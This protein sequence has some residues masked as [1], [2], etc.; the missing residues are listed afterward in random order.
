[1][2]TVTLAEALGTEKLQQFLAIARRYCLFIEDQQPMPPVVFLPQVQQLLLDLYTAALSLDWINLQSKADYETKKIDLP[3]ILRVVAEKLDNS[4][5]YWS[6]FDPTSESD[7]EAGCGDLLD[8]LGDIYKDLAC[9]LI[10]FDLQTADSQENAL[11]QFKFDFA[12]HWGDHC[13][14]ALRA[15]HFFLAEE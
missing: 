14:N 3:K 8:D 5:Y 12:K 4:R 6:V 10:I 15:L 1:M 11:W 2:K 7:A 9:S 13:I